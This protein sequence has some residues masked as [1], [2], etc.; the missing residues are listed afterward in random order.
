MDATSPS[1]A[2]KRHD[3]P[4]PFGWFA[5]ARSSELEAGQV[6]PRDFCAT[7]FV[8]WRGEDGAVR[9]LDAYCPPLGAPLAYARGTQ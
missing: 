5:V 9:A 6:M 2:R 7:E 1:S 3:L 8:L 4:L